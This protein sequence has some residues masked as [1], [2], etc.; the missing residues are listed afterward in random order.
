MPCEN[1][2]AMLEKRTWHKKAMISAPQ[3]SDGVAFLT[4]GLLL[5][6]KGII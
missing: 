2:L 4:L 3:R 6:M 5:F 1:F